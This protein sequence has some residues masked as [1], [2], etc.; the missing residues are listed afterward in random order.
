M[1]QPRTAADYAALIRPT[2]L[3]ESPVAFFRFAPVAKAAG[4]REVLCAPRQCELLLQSHTP[5][6]LLLQRFSQFRGVTLC[7]LLV[8]QRPRAP[9]LPA[10]SALR[11]R[12]GQPRAPARGGRPARVA[13]SGIAA[14]LPCLP[15]PACPAQSPRLPSPPTPPGS[16]HRP[17]PP[18]PPLLAVPPLH[19][20][21]PL[22]FA[23]CLPLLPPGLLRCLRRP[24]RPAPPPRGRVPHP[25]RPP[26]PLP[27]G[28]SQ[29]R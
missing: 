26:P 2:E 9:S 18:P 13:G 27:Q 4:H 22:C 16:P 23:S 19:A 28:F 25:A 5:R 11:R 21:L 8:A 10:L 6:S 1:P 17:A 14:A 29:F 20:S 24:P 12:A 3:N 7:D 15:P